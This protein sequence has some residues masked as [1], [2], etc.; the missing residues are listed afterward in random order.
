[1]QSSQTGYTNITSFGMLVTRL[2][3]VKKD[4]AK[5]EAT[6]HEVFENRQAITLRNRSEGEVQKR[7]RSLGR[8]P[9]VAVVVLTNDDQSGV[10]AS[11]TVFGSTRELRA[12]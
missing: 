7:K 11:F 10:L 4:S 1:M 8:L 12:K 6:L 9:T 3:A 5:I 2:T